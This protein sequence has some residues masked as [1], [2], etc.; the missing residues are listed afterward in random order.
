MQ[1]YGPGSRKQSSPDN[2]TEVKTCL[3]LVPVAIQVLAEF[4]K[5]GKQREGRE[6]AVVPRFWGNCPISWL[7]AV[8][9][10]QMSI[11]SPCAPGTCRRGDI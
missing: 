5:K 1:P 6:A 8:G 9:H 10:V 3:N 4:P 2:S 7:S 11:H